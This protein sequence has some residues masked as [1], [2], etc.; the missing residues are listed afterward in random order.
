M[1]TT[2]Q[3]TSEDESG[4]LRARRQRMNVHQSIDLLYQDHTKLLYANSRLFDSYKSILQENIRLRQS[5]QL[6]S[7]HESDPDSEQD[8][9]SQG[10][11]Q[12]RKNTSR[13][14]P[15]EERVEQLQTS[16]LETA[17]KPRFE[18]CCPHCKYVIVTGKK[19]EGAYAP[20]SDGEYSSCVDND[21][22][23]ARLEPPDLD[24]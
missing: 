2:L 5:A 13:H 16:N 24:V 17:L 23:G 8:S 19:Q 3:N 21:D 11:E 6:R 10:Q 14:R 9:R 7:A 18:I 20:A 1:A 12:V 4:L 22:E 15:S